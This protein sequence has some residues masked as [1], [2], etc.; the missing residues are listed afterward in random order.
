[1]S[2]ILSLVGE[3]KMIAKSDIMLNLS[4]DQIRAVI[5][6]LL[7]FT[8]FVFCKLLPPS[9]RKSGLLLVIGW[10]EHGQK[11]WLPD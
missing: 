4:Y 8:E 7:I 3:I 1:M 9:L 10:V 5:T 2:P 11:I 6:A